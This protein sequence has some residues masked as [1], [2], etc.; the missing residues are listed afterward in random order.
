MDE[1]QDIKKLLKP[2]R[3]IVAS[4][5]L[6]QRVKEIKATKHRQIIRRQRQWGVAACVAIVLAGIL[7]HHIHIGAGINEADCVVYAAG[8]QIDGH[9]AQEIAEADVAKMQQFMLIINEKQ[10][11]EETK[12]EYFM[13]Q[14]NQ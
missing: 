14:I 11:Q 2:H 8:E 12:V 7:L 1:Y 13:N 9:A 10:N 5:K 3:K 6:C 4:A